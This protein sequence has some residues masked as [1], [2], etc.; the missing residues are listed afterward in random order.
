MKKLLL[1]LFGITFILSNIL[2]MFP[3]SVVS[4]QYSSTPLPEN[5]WGEAELVADFIEWCIPSIDSTLIRY[6]VEEG[7]LF[8]QNNDHKVHISPFITDGGEVDKDGIRQCQN[9]SKTA[10]KALY[11][12]TEAFADIF[13]NASGDML[14]EWCGNIAEGKEDGCVSYSGLSTTIDIN[15]IQNTLREK[16]KQKGY[17]SKIGSALKPT[18]SKWYEYRLLRPLFVNNCFKNSG[19]RDK[20]VTIQGKDYYY[21]GKASD[22][23]NV[24]IVIDG[25]NGQWNC[26]EMAEHVNTDRWAFVALTQDEYINQEN[27]DI[28]NEDAAA[29]YEAIMPIFRAD[30][31]AFASCTLPTIEKYLETDALKGA[32][33]EDIMN[34]IGLWIASWSAGTANGDVPWSDDEGQL[35]IACL[36]KDD[37]FGSQLANILEREP[38]V[39]DPSTVD[40]ITASPEAEAE[41]VQ[42]CRGGSG[43]IDGFLGFILCPLAE[44][45]LRTI[46]WAQNN[47]IMPYLPI[48]PLV[49]EDGQSV[50]EMWKIVRNIAYVFLIVGFMYLVYAETTGFG[51]EAYQL[52]RLAPRLVFVTIGISLSFTIAGLIV[53]F[54]NILGAGIDELGPLLI[55]GGGGNARVTTSIFGSLA[56][57][58]G[59]LGGLLAGLMSGA[60]GVWPILIALLAGILIVCAI[61]IT[62]LLRQALVL[63]LVILAPLAIAAALLPNTEKFT[64]TWWSYLSKAL[65]MYPIVMMLFVGGKL[66]GTLITNPN[67]IPASGTGSGALKSL[68]S[69][70]A[71]IAPLVLVPFT[72]KMAGGALGSIYGALRGAV[73]KGR[74]AVMGDPHNPNSIRGR[75]SERASKWNRGLHRA[76]S[77]LGGS[78]N[79]LLRY[80]GAAGAARLASRG[81]RLQERAALAEKQEAEKAAALM[82]DVDDDVL[83]QTVLGNEKISKDELIAQGFTEAQAQETL[84]AFDHTPKTENVQA[85]NSLR[86]RWGVRRQAYA[87]FGAEHGGNTARVAQ[88]RAALQRDVANN[89]LSSRQADKLWTSFA[90]GAKKAGKGAALDN[91]RGADGRKAS[92]WNGDLIAASSSTQTL[93]DHVTDMHGSTDV[94]RWS[95]H[96]WRMVDLAL[97]NEELMKDE[98]Y[99]EKVL[100]LAQK[101]SEHVVSSH[102]PG[103][104]T[105][106][107]TAP[108]EEGGGVLGGRG[109]GLNLDKVGIMKKIADRTAVARG[110]R[111]P[112]AT[113]AWLNNNDPGDVT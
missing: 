37:K 103:A 14:K 59:G 77:R 96:D 44:G 106:V 63:I 29:K 78:S 34:Y 57:T 28:R 5:K 62:L 35:M 1:A 67:F 66:L 27:T 50:Y 10:M 48:M 84:D 68:I 45:I 24:G 16:A 76:T 58:A 33:G 22:P 46:D 80:S 55:Q 42:N 17:Y 11:G 12:S 30:P 102:K 100:N 71:N 38:D 90:K 83:K 52:K 51:G 9:L 81:L 95:D 7:L 40:D 23:I 72:F 65:V 49:P 15:K 8:G 111:K 19:D 99:R 32:S 13:Y 89:T 82:H 93:K 41:E 85:S 26:G 60:I 47:L 109:Y 54:F 64:K 88:V 18:V 70:M 36:I 39:K 92:A 105:D 61:V 86:S 4:A 79:R 91:M 75:S 112:S 87:Q 53:D 2:V 43:L 101:A 110:A 3:T 98:T 20:K 69:F 74:N 6:E 97:D 25:G 104:G 73:G 56:V 107:E 94:E 31:I 108:A 21:K 113:E